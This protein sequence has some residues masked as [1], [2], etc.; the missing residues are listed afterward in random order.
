[1]HLSKA[2][3]NAER[4]KLCSAF[5]FGPN[6]MKNYTVQELVEKIPMDFSDGVPNKRSKAV[7]I[8]DNNLHGINL[9]I[10]QNTSDLKARERAT[11][12]RDAH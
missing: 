2:K 11:S 10:W 9:A 7:E 1:M 5:N 4:L 12:R 3:D 8:L 6:P